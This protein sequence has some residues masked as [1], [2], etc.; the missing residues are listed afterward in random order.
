[1][2]LHYDQTLIEHALWYRF[3]AVG[4]LI[5][6]VTACTMIVVQA[7]LDST[8]LKTVNYPPPTL[9]GSF[10]AFGSI[11]FAFAGASTFP[12]IQADM[13]HREKFNTSAVIACIS[14]YREADTCTA[15]CFFVR[16]DVLRRN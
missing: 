5:T 16:A 7:C 4:A 6:T 2:N 10:K 9:E 14:K 11:M 8:E 15:V 13:K 3:I 1:M 12:T